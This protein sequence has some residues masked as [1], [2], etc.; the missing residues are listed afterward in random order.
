MKALTVFETCVLPELLGKRYTRPSSNIEE[1]KETHKNHLLP[2]QINQILIVVHHQL[3]ENKYRYCRGPE[4]G[5]MIA[6]E[7]EDCAIEW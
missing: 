3:S 6:S 4:E 1:S 5:T 7:N 2:L